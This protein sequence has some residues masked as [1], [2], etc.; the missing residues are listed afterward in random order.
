MAH[1]RY[2]L[3]P[4]VLIF[5]LGTLA[6]VTALVL[7]GMLTG[8]MAEAAGGA[9]ILSPVGFG[10]IAG[11]YAKQAIPDPPRGGHVEISSYSGDHDRAALIAR[12]DRDRAAE[13]DAAELDRLAE[14]GRLSELGGEPERPEVTPAER[15]GA[16]RAEAA[17][18][19]VIPGAKS[20]RT[21]PRK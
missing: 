20:G 6:F 12:I 4:L 19:E 16:K 1:H 18:P 10:L 5:G 13:R 3:D 21:L 7:V 8:H 17:R 14:V 2:R 9:A 15:P 11:R